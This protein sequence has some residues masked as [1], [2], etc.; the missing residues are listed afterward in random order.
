M[1][2]TQRKTRGAS[3]SRGSSLPEDYTAVLADLTQMIRAARLRSLSAVNRELVL[4][5]WQVGRSIVLKQEQAAW[6]DSVV[7][8]LSVDLRSEFRDMK[9]FTSGGLW[10]MRQFYNACREINTWAIAKL[11]RSRQTRDASAGNPILATVW[12][13]LTPQFGQLLVSLSWSHHRLIMGSSDR[14]DERFFYLN[15]AVREHW[16][17][18]ELER[19]IESDLF[20]R[21][22]SVKRDPEKCLPQRTESGE[23]LPF[24]DH[25]IL[26]FLGLED[27][28]TE[29]QLR[30]A[31][32]AN[33]RGVFLEFGRDFALV[34]EEHPIT[35]G[36]ETY[37]IDLL[38]FHRKLQCLVAV[39]L[40][41]GK[42]KPEYIGKCQFYLAALDEFARLPHEK[43]SVGL[44]LCKNAG[45]GVQMRLALT[46]AAR[47][48]GVATYQTA[49]PDEETIVRQMGGA[50]ASMKSA[51]SG[52]DE[53]EK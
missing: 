28:H 26:D 12:R 45:G 50:L 48:L 31:M 21:F 18:R 23:L 27:R 47:R 7:E 32:L 6:G 49:L 35:V 37:R 5:Y 33:F 10:R 24:K 53:G 9:G 17:V 40:K 34:G 8:Q 25:Y 51:T 39:E 38:F 3:K 13:E 22:V 11:P 2:T 1:N 42:F 43:P 46:L 30:K 16:S 29:R 41:S 20:T 19:Q 52:S 4:L 14:A 15:M 44:V 36:D